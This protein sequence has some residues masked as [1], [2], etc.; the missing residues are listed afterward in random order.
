MKF[1]KTKKGISLL[2][3][4]ALVAIAAVG[5]YAYFSSSGDGSGTGT[6]GHATA[7]TVTGAG[8]TGNLYPY[9]QTQLDATPAL[10]TALTGGSVSNPASGTG[11]Q[12]LTTLT[13]T[14][15]A[16]TGGSG[17]PNACTA[18]DFRLYSPTPGTW[19]ISGTNNGVATISPGVSL[20]PGASYSM[21]NLSVAMVDSGAN[22]DG[23]QGATVHIAYHA[24]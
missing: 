1:I 4:V 20:A 16:P 9:T 13:A 24:S 6:V 7:F 2:A 8:E 5:A 10:Y 12:F 15:G 11:N 18:A 17:V 14:I 23:C 21:T 19:T 3:V 22:Q